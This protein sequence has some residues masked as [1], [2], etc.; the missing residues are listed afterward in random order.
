LKR[1]LNEALPADIAI[2]SVEEM[3]AKFDAR[4]H[5]I[6]RSYVYQISTRKTAFS[7]KYVWWIKEP[8]DVAKMRDAA[9]M[10]PGRHDFVRFCAK[11]PSKPGQSTIVVV[12]SA[13][14]EERDDL[15]LFHIEATHFL[16]RMVRRLAGCLVKVGLGELPVQGFAELLAAR[17]HNLDAASWTAP[18]AGLF[19][20]KVNYPKL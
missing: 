18:A 3:P 6:S 8:L 16:M 13:S 5:A 9:A 14:V 17:G 2:L 20:K 19:L 11:D 1:L 15:I 10:I 7:K 4:Q 12:N